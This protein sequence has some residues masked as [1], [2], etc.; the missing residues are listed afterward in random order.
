MRA[1]KQCDMRDCKER[2]VFYVD[3]IESASNAIGC[4]LCV[5]HMVRWMES[6]LE[7]LRSNS[8]DDRRRT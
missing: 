1:I 8:H 5:E 6:T 4:S 3:Y 2:S 7:F